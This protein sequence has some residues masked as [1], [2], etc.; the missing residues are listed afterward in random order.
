MTKK[1][2]GRTKDV[3]FQPYDREGEDK[4]KKEDCFYVINT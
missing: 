3:R 2:N 4:P 1:E